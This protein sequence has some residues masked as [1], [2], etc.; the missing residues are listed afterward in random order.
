[1][2]RVERIELTGQPTWGLNNIIHK[3]DHLP[4]RLVADGQGE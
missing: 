1:V 2:S 4:L 3:L